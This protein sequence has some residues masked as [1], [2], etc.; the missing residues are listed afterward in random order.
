MYDCHNLYILLVVKF[1]YLLSLFIVCEYH[2][3]S[4]KIL[5]AQDCG[6]LVSVRINFAIQTIVEATD[7]PL[8]Y[9]SYLIQSCH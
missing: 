5:C 6:S 3:K 1:Q 9:R 2:L 7:R 4:I 8:Y